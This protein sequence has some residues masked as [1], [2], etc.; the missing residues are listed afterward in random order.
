MAVD[1]SPE[2]SVGA[3]DDDAMV[4]GVRDEAPVMVDALTMEGTTEADELACKLRKAQRLYR[5]AKAGVRLGSHCDWLWMQ[6]MMSFGSGST[7]LGS[8]RSCWVK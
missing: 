5:S 6:S 7:M 4:T 1:P 8:P 2:G 3:A